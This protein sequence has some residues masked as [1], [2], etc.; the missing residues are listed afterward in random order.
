[1]AHGANVV[2]EKPSTLDT[3]CFVDN[4]A[5]VRSNTTISN[6]IIGE[7][8]VIGEKAVLINTFVAPGFHVPAATFAENMFFGYTAQ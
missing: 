8:A 7:R 5:V 4:E 6:S 2:I 3:G 1:V